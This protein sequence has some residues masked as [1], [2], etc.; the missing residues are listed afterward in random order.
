MEIAELR[1]K[2]IRATYN[3]DAVDIAKY[4]SLV[5]QKGHELNLVIGAPDDLSKGIP[6]EGEYVI[7]APKHKAEFPKLEGIGVKIY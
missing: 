1:I 7:E 3:K 2:L 6:Q 5:E 4:Y